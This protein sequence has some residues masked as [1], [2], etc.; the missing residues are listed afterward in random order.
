MHLSIVAGLNI[1]I[2]NSIGFLLFLVLLVSG[3]FSCVIYIV[4]C[5]SNF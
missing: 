5:V 4:L 2:N 1:D 3:E